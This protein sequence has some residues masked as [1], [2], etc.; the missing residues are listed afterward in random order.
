VPWV[1]VEVADPRL[2]LSDPSLRFRW[3]KRRLVGRVYR[4]ASRVIANSEGVR[5]GLIDYYRLP[6]RAVITLY[7]SVDIERLDR[8]VPVA[9]PALEPGRFHV[10]CAGR[11]HRQKG[12]IYLLRAV[13]ELVNGRGRKELA[14]H[15]LGQGPL[16][17]ELKEFVS[18]RGLA[19]HVF[20]PGFTPNPYSWFRQAQLFCLP[21]LYEGMP[22]ALLE[23]MACGVPVLAADCPSGP[24]EILDGGKYGRLVPPGDSAALADAILHAMDHYEEWRAIVPLARARIEQD[25][26]VSVGV[27]RLE[28]LLLEVC[29]RE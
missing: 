13:D 16:E 27:K 3:L 17:A 15:V 10:V 1:A 25:F 26:S 8:L 12:Y 2:G 4:S 11:L 22:N 14:V 6:E 21:S 20:F 28:Q 18:R 19:G 5:Q 24:S 23:A 7:N 29:E 9:E